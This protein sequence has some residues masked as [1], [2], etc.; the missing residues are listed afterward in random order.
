MSDST[1]SPSSILNFLRFKW[2]SNS[3]RSPRIVFRL[4]EKG[5]QQSQQ[6][7]EQ[8]AEAETFTDK[9]NQQNEKK[10]EVPTIGQLDTMVEIDST[11]VKTPKGILKKG[12]K[13]KCNTTN[14]DQS[15]QN[16]QVPIRKS[17]SLMCDNLN[18]S[19]SKKVTFSSETKNTEPEKNL[20]Y[21]ITRRNFK[22]V[23]NARDNQSVE[24]TSTNN[25]TSSAEP[26]ISGTPRNIFKITR[27]TDL[28]R[29]LKFSFNSNVHSP[30][31]NETEA[32][33]K[34]L[35]KIP[36]FEQVLESEAP[37]RPYPSLQAMLEDSP[38]SPDTDSSD[39]TKS[40]PQIGSLSAR[41]AQTKSP[42]E[43]YLPDRENS[44]SLT[45]RDGLLVSKGKREKNWEYYAEIEKKTPFV[46]P[47]KPTRPDS[48][49]GVRPSS[50]IGARANIGALIQRDFIRPAVNPP[51]R[52]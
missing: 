7:T 35:L 15:P 23:Q 1:S 21:R 51:E 14:L 27:T 6:Q 50:K 30:K 25:L 31:P 41:N 11:P 44:D 36:S 5:D 32:S 49:A 3:K 13:V 9:V 24:T 22:I 12:L 47:T 42:W 46:L 48:K 52:L 39:M 45:P 28:T 33:R 29:S 19:K 20:R 4:P 10:F 26:V 16:S 34:N 17:E 43:G 2:I 40:L 8:R 18:E 37:T 38:I